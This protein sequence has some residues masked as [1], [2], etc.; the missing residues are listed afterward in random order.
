[1]K[2][3]VKRYGL[4][5]KRIKKI[6]KNKRDSKKFDRVKNIPAYLT[7]K[8]SEGEMDLY[9]FD[10]S[11]FTLDPYI[12][13][14][15]QPE[16]ENIEIPLSKSGRIN[17]LGFRRRGIDSH[18]LRFQVVHPQYTPVETVFEILPSLVMGQT[19][20]YRSQSVIT[21]IKCPYVRFQAR[22]QGDEK[23]IRPCLD[24]IKAM[25]TLGKKVAQPT[26]DDLAD[27]QPFPITMCMKVFIN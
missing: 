17:V 3:T 2:K 13:Y 9:Y 4:S 20:Q 15:R 19:V 6:L 14:A 24:M 23:P 27:T 5:W 26:H 21:E 8:D 7:E 18:L 16:G 10:E 1:M 11:G 22:A 25:I 12:P